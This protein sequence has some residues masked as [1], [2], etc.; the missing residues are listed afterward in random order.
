MKKEKVFTIFEV[1]EQFD[2]LV[3]GFLYDK[4]KYK[5]ITIEGSDLKFEIKIITDKKT[6]KL[7]NYTEQL[8]NSNIIHTIQYNYK[9]LYIYVSFLDKIMDIEDLKKDFVSIEKGLLKFFIST[10]LK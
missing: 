3:H 2:K 9:K 1:A 10:N 5:K 6:K 4:I 7:I 8:Q